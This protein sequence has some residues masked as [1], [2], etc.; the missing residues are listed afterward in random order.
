MYLC[1]NK[2]LHSFSTDHAKLP[3]CSCQNEQAHQQLLFLN[4]T[5]LICCSLMYPLEKLSNRG[6]NLR[7]IFERLRE[8]W[9]QAASYSTQLQL[10]KTCSPF[11]QRVFSHTIAFAQETTAFPASFELLLDSAVILRMIWLRSPQMHLLQGFIQLDLKSLCCRYLQCCSDRKGLISS[12]DQTHL[13]LAK[14][15]VQYITAAS[16]TKC[17]AVSFTKINRCW[18][19]R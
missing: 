3:K 1:D 7:L 17:S 14:E 9:S 19:C 6:V 2:V 13:S 10:W 15:H 12:P 5:C 4:A 8:C 18:L 11:L 16:F